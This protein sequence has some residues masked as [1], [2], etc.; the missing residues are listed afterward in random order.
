MTI[1]TKE[2]FESTKK[3]LA[4]A[5]R[6]LKALRDDLLP[7]R[8]TEYEAF[9]GAYIDNVHR[10]R[11][12]IDEYLGLVSAEEDSMMLWVRIQ[13]NQITDRAPIS[14]VSNFLKDFRNGIYQIAKYNARS[15]G[16]RIPADAELQRLTDPRIKVMSGSL[17]IGFALPPPQVSL[18]GTIDNLPIDAIKKM[19]L[20]ASWANG[21]NK[22]PLQELLPDRIERYLVL[23]NVEKISSPKG[24][25]VTIEF[26]GR[27]LKGKRLM[28]TKDAAQKAKH[29]ITEDLPQE[30]IS[31]EGVVREIDL[32][33]MHFQ[34]KIGKGGRRQCNYPPELE[35]EV[36][37]NLDRRIKAIGESHPATGAKEPLIKVK[38]IET[39]DEAE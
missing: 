27:L 24:G 7:D 16:G 22:K 32:D 39:I 5:E 6:A 30:M 18:E 2:E 12:E 9:S 20:G 15:R 19:L 26:R 37:S 28:M 10:L 4:S 8:T 38:M 13:G 36:K 14:I 17:R 23:H 11:Y 34:L 1:R 31:V 3:V 29:A 25:K 35:D 21:T 33:H